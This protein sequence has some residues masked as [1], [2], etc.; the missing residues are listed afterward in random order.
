MNKTHF[1]LFFAGLIAGTPFALLANVPEIQKSA[2]TQL[3][4]VADLLVTPPAKNA[5]QSTPADTK[6]AL[7]YA[8]S[9]FL[10]GT[11]EKS[12]REQ[13]K[14]SDAGKTPQGN[15]FGSNDAIEK[16]RKNEIDFAL[17]MTPGLNTIP[18]IQKGTLR[19]ITIGYQISYVVVPKSNPITEISFAE[20]E[21]IYSEFAKK[22]TA[23]WSELEG[24]R[25]IPF[26]VH[27][28]L[29]SSNSSN[30]ITFFQ[31]KVFP[32]ADFRKSVRH[33]K[34]DDD[35]IREVRE[36]NNAIAIIGKPIVKDA[37]LK[38]IA[39]SA[40]RDAERIF[41]AYSPEPANIY[42]DDYPL[43]LPIYLIYA[44]TNRKK[45]VPVFKTIFSDTFAESITQAG[46]ASIPQNI[47][48]NY[49]KNIDKIGE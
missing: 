42:N 2:S 27:A 29:G 18:E 15:F 22:P 28:V 17:I 24:A 32:K 8:G 14:A 13:I 45:I 38:T 31:A 34:T 48:E 44:P 4:D 11:V 30:A 10:A 49:K 37:H 23:V 12:L 43:S 6:T 9:D 21:N 26:T 35:A 19:A 39:V 46:F 3:S 16:L 5:T 7:K 40:T 20:L 33:A 41:P 25:Q 36:F 1:T 47:R